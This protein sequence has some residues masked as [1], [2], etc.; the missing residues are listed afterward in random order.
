MSDNHGYG[1]RLSNERDRVANS[2]L[3]EA[4]RDALMRYLRA[5]DSQLDLSPA[6]VTNRVKDVRVPCERAGASLKAM[7]SVDD[8]NQVL[9][10]LKH[11]TD[12]SQGTLRNYRKAFRLFF[13]WR[14]DSWFD[15]IRV[16]AAPKRP[17][18]E[19]DVLDSD[20][21][22]ALVEAAKGTRD[23]ALIAFMLDTGFRIGAAVS[24]RIGDIDLTER[25]AT[26][27]FNEDGPV[28]G[29]TGTVLVT[30][31]HSDISS[32]L[33]IHP[34]RENPDAPLFF[35]DDSRASESDLFLSYQAARNVIA[36]AA[37]KADL[38][39]VTPHTL[40]KTAISQWINDRLTDR[41]IKHRAGWHKDS[42]QFQQY[43]GLTDSDMN[44]QIAEHYGLSADG[45]GAEPLVSECPHCNRPI[46][47]SDRFCPGCASPLTQS[48]A[49][50][51]ERMAEA[52]EESVAG[53]PPDSAHEA[54]AIWRKVESS[55][56]L[57]E[58]AADHADSSDESS[59]SNSA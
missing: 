14:G 17:V 16:G 36:K 46:R 38:K 4:D 54:L 37:D 59:S 48:A 41:E 51:A 3:S 31:S 55:P 1:R 49:T 35:R 7:Q 5:I 43:D 53:L 21:V 34:D 13:K 50:V 12:L 52:G 18:S 39:G 19:D 32:L 22:D 57:K 33:R 44:G 9:F 30:W 20:E 11:D 8:V 10:D 26:V 27:S 28:K 23:T 40:R 2:A 42:S 45:D 15:E 58:W 47:S 25:P 24:L 29:A 56:E 6:T